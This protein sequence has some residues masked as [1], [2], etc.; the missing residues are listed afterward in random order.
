MDDMGA[1]ADCTGALK[2]VNNEIS[3]SGNFSG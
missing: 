2:G 1:Q 3:K